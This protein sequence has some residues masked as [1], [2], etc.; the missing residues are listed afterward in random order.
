MRSLILTLAAVAVALPAMAQT[1]TQ[2]APSIQFGDAL[3]KL[4]DSP[5]NQEKLQQGIAIAS[6]MGCTGK[7]AGKPATDAFYKR[8]Q[9]TGKSVEK[10]CKAKRAPEA[11]ALVLKTLKEVESDPVRIAANNCYTTQ[12]EDFDTLAGP[13]LANDAENYAR[14]I[15]DPALA[16]QEMTDGD[17]C[18]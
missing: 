11:R 14:W 5:E 16:E 7:A 6:L 13:K 1:T 17:I 4:L 3:Q 10:L 2:K 8:M 9:A 15:A 18:K 12:K